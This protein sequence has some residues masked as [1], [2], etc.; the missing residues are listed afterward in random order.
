[1]KKILVPVDFNPLATAALE[2]AAQ[3]AAKSGAT[4]LVM[5]ADTFEP[6]V[7]FTAMQTPALLT[8]LAE[9]RSNT[10]EELA[11]YVH[12]HVP[13]TLTME[14]EVR[15]ALP[16][17]AILAAIAEHQPDL[18]VMGTHGRGGLSRLLFGSVTETVLR[19][20]KVPVLTMNRVDATLPPRTVYGGSHPIAEL[21]GAT[22]VDDVASADLIVITD[23]DRDLTRHARAPVLHVPS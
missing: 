17:P 10:A 4:L 2:Y 12:E 7:E 16:V 6:P 8:A 18:V 1:M 15:E 21:F 23:G 22:V 11:E 13:E 3:I 19:E 9:S 14:T 20:A 5:Y